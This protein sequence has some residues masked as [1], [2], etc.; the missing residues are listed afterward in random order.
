MYGSAVGVALSVFITV[1]F[2]LQKT[3]SNLVDLW[4]A[5][6]VAQSPNAL[7]QGNITV[8]NEDMFNLYVFAGLVGL[9]TVIVLVLVL[10]AAYGC[11]R[12]AR[13]IHKRVLQR[14]FAV[15]TTSIFSKEHTFY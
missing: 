14:V 8:S 13:A 3:S 15:S 12:A 9:N 5:H 6:W 2:I 11:L 1:M 4:L 7:P 10:V